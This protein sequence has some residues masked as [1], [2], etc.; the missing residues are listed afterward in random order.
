MPDIDSE[1]L[2]KA[3]TYRAELS[4]QEAQWENVH[5]WIDAKDIELPMTPS[6]DSPPDERLYHFYIWANRP[7]HISKD[8]ELNIDIVGCKATK[9]PVTYS[10]SPSASPS[11][12]VT[13]ITVSSK[14]ITGS[15][16][17]LAWFPNQF[18]SWEKDRQGQIHQRLAELKNDFQ[19]EHK[20]RENKN[21]ASKARELESLLRAPNPFG[22]IQTVR[23]FNGDLH[24]QIYMLSEDEV[25]HAFG[26]DFARFFH[27]GKAY[28]LNKH[29][30]KDLIVHT[31][32]MKARCLFYR[33]PDDDLA[34]Y[35]DGLEDPYQRYQYL[36]LLGVPSVTQG[37][38]S[39]S[40]AEVIRNKVAIEVASIKPEQFN[41]AER[42]KLL[43]DLG[44][45]INTAEYEVAL[46]LVTSLIPAIR[47]IYVQL[48]DEHVPLDTD[49]ERNAEDWGVFNSLWREEYGEKSDLSGPARASHAGMAEAIKRAVPSV[50]GAAARV[51]SSFIERDSVLSRPR[52]LKVGPTGKTAALS[53]NFFRE[54]LYASNGVLWEDYYRPMTFSAVLV[55]LLRI[56]DNR[57]EKRVL[58]WLQS[59]GVLAGAL[60]GV[61]ALGSWW[62]SGIYT[63]ATGLTTSV[64]LPELRKRL[65]D[66]IGQ[67]IANLGALA[68]DTVVSIPPNGSRDGYVFFPR[69]PIFGYGISEFSIDEPSFIVNIDNLDVVA[70][71][72]LV[73]KG[74]QISSGAL[75]AQTQ[76]QQARNKGESVRAQQDEDLQ[77]IAS[78][79]QAYR[80]A[81]LE[82]EVNAKIR[83]KQ[84]K[85]ANALI[86]DYV[87]Q[88]GTDLTGKI[89]QLRAAALAQDP[90]IRFEVLNASDKAVD[91]ILL[92]QPD[93]SKQVYNAN[94]KVHLAY[95][96]PADKRVRIVNATVN[97]PNTTITVTPESWE[98][99]NNSGEWN[100][101]QELAVTVAYDAGQT[102]K[103]PFKL[104]LVASSD[105]KDFDGAVAE[106]ELTL[107]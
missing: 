36:Q 65:L 67:Y 105:D 28:F 89:A 69:G 10:N 74:T 54:G 83:E 64:L 72:M 58:D 40:Q 57:L 86:D 106:V 77:R 16:T 9:E 52:A 61:T 20:W 48:L 96:L 38:M 79:L 39:S 27:V 55:S 15:F 41:E 12:H 35:F 100:K 8:G 102:P 49:A 50:E 6:G 5:V 56:N 70:D 84:Y 99:T 60:V 2:A 11:E 24:T 91:A 43:Q 34:K 45:A 30:D 81:I 44:Y 107:P 23:V 63:A 22:A 104:K 87:S 47:S 101:P 103:G 78:Q 51:I 1:D 3:T 98:F 59:A 62:G 85:A 94:L 31:T 73:A 75:D 32:S 37:S 53:E 95:K 25:V 18:E 90:E 46:E 66:D 71:G 76:T 68:L 4:V 42:Q 80:L 14:D 88:F 97:P 7:S 93:Q 82:V 19:D 92:T 26:P 33:E 17:I 13:R 29:P 21:F